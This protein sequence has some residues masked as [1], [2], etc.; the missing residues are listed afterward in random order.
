MQGPM[1][2]KRIPVAHA[3]AMVDGGHCARN[4]VEHDK[5]A[6]NRTS[7]RTDARVLA[8]LVKGVMFLR[9]SK[10]LLQFEDS[11][12]EARVLQLDEHL[13][14]VIMIIAHE[15]PRPAGALRINSMITGSSGPTQTLQ[16]IR[17]APLA[18]LNVE[19]KACLVLPGDERHCEKAAHQ[20]FDI[21]ANASHIVIVHR[22]R[23]GSGTPGPRTSTS[24]HGAKRA[25]EST[26]DPSSSGAPGMKTSSSRFF[27]DWRQDVKDIRDSLSGRRELQARDERNHRPPEPYQGP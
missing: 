14:H 21:L 5:A 25:A 24:L 15:T 26:A 17:H 7:W 22:R 20:T 11:T 8:E 6:G 16:D 10:R 4:V 13:I 9:F 1:R 18:E 19:L 27:S 3:D 23:Q 2:G 12:T